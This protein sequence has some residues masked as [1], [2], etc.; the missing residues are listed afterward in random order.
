MHRA[1]CLFA[2]LAL[3]AP[4]AAQAPALSIDFAQA[5]LNG[6]PFYEYN[7]DRITT[8]LGRPSAVEADRFNLGAKVYY[9][10]L[11]L[12][13]WF[14]PKSLDPQERAWMVIVY[15]SRSWDSPRKEF[16]QPFAGT[17]APAVSANWKA[18]QTLKALAQLGPVERPAGAGSPVHVVAIESKTHKANFIHERTTLFLE[19][20]ALIARDSLK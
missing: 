5:T 14:H 1:T 19:R 6:A 11:G 20:V 2:A 3:V 7:V 17:L 18:A 4:V 9:H 12:E 10:A 13:I 15:L 16:F 8:L